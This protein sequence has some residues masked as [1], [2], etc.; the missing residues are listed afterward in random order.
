MA[1]KET[2]SKFSTNGKTN[3]RMEETEGNATER[4]NVTSAASDALDRNEELA[5]VEIATLSIIL[6]VTV[7]GNWLV[8]LA[9][10]ARKCR[11][12][13]KALSRMYFFIFHLCVADLITA[14][15]NVLPQLI[16]D[17]TYR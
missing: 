17:V 3:S 11:A 5:Q 15:F 2:S 8:L 10:Y 6:V 14:F 12:G 4:K 16:W 13:K 1:S 7:L 9:L